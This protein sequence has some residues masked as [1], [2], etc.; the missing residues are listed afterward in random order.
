[1][2]RVIIAGVLIAIIFGLYLYKHSK[3]TE[4]TSVLTLYGNIDVRQ[5]DLG[6][7]VGGRVDKMFFDEG[8]F[9]TQG[10]LM[11]VLEP[12]P[13]NQQLQQAVA[14]LLATNLS[15][16]NAEAYFKRRD[17]LKGI[18]GVSQEDFDNARTSR[19]V[20]AANLRQG[21]AAVAI[22][23]KNF[24]DTQVFA[25]TNGFVLTR[26]QEPGAVVKESDP[27]YTLSIL[28]PVWVRA[29]ISEPYLGRVHPGMLAD[30][31]T[32]S[33]DGKVY[34]GHVGYIS[35]VSEFTPKTVETTQLRTDLVYRLRIIADNPDQGLRQGMPV[36]VK[37]HL[38]VPENKEIHE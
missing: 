7:R 1:M 21:E 8:D 17:E 12:E 23:A 2:R 35:P 22:A 15:L 19:Y 27:I 3:F 33:H 24:Q 29:F 20:Y 37:L 9:V 16:E 4:D 38:N 30:I 32:D 6:F 28:S 11:G 18:G 10:A 14:A 31:Y 25:P 26:I 34:Q 5:V 13:Y 36:T